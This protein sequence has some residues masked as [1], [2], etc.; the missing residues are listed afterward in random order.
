[1]SRKKS[2]IDFEESLDKINRIV[3]EM[4]SGGLSLEESL[5][6]FEEGV[7]LTQHCQKALQAAEQKVQILLNESEL[8]DFNMPSEKL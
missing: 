6:R 5:K 7:L 8:V 3:E 2:E 4:E 1:M